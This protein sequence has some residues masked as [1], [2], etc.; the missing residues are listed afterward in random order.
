MATF[1]VAPP[2][3]FSFRPNDWPKWLQRWERFR[4]ASELTKKPEETQI[5]TFIYSMGEDADDI[6]STLPLT[7]EERK[8]YNTVI[9]K[10]ESHFIIKRNVIFERAKF[11][12]RIQQE[13]EPVDAF[14]TDLHTLAQHC[15]YGALHD[16]MIRDRIVVGLRDKALS[17]KLQLESDLTLEKAVNQARQK[18]LVRQQQEVLRPQ[19]QQGIGSIDRLKFKNSTDKK[20]PPTI[21]FTRPKVNP[22]YT[23]CGHCGGKP[24][25]RNEC[26][27]KDSTCNACRK[28]GHWKKMCRSTKKVAEVNQK[29]ESELF[30]GE[31]HIDHLKSGNNQWKVDIMVND[32][33]V[34]FKIDSGA[35]VSVLPV[36]TYEKL[37]N[38]KLQPTSKVLLGPC[39]Y[40]LN[41]MGKFKAKLTVNNLSV[42]NDVYVVKDLERP[43]LSR[44]DSQ[45]LNLINK[46]ETIN[47]FES[48]SEDYKGKIT[49]KYPKLFKGL[50]QIAGE[51]SI[52]L[53][54]H[55]TPFALSVPRKVPLPL[56]SKTKAEIQRML[57]MGV[58]RKVE[59]PTE[60]C[61]PMVV[62]PKANGQ[63]RICVDLTKL[64]ANI[65]REFHPLP[66]VDF[67]LGKL[68]DARV[69]SKLDA[70][71]AF[72]QRALAEESKL[73]TTFITPWGRFCFERLP[74]GISTGSGQ[75]Q[76][77]MME[78]LEGLE[79]VECQ[80]DDIVVHGRTQE[81]HDKR[82]HQVL[83]SLEKANITLNLD[84]CEFNK[85]QIKILG[86]IVSSNRIS[87]DPEKVKAI[88]DLP[89]P[90][91]ISQTRS[92]LGMVNQL[93][94]FTDH[95]ADKTKPIRDLLSEK[96]SWSW[97]Q[98]QDKAFKQIKQCLISPPVLALYD[99]NKKTK[100]TSDASSYGLG[101]VVLQQ[102]DD[103]TWKPVAYFS[104]ALTNTE[105]HYSQ[106]E[107]E[108]L[109]FTWLCERASD[110]I[111]GKPIVGETDHKPLVPMLMTHCLDQLPP[112][113]Q[114][115]RMRLMRF[116]IQEMIHVPGKNMYTSDTLSRMMTKETA[117]KETSQ[118]DENETEAFVCSIMDALPI[119]DLKLQQLIEAQDQDEVCKQLRQYC[120]E[121]W[122]E[123]HLLPSPIHPY[124]SDR[125]Q[126]TVVQN[127]LLM[128]S[129]IVIPS[130][131][132]L[133]VLDKLH[134]GHQGISKC[135]E[136]AKQ[137]VWWP[138]LSKQIQDMID[139][140][141]I[142]LKHKVNRPE[143]LCT[144]LFPQRPWQELGADFFQCQSCDYLIVVDYYSRYIEIAAMNKNKKST[145]VVRALKSIM[146]RH[147][148]PE[149][150]RSDNGPPFDSG[151]YA[152][153]ANEWGFAI[154]T[155]SPKFPRSNGEAERAVQTAKSILKK[156]RDQAKALLAYRSTPL[157]CG[158]SPAQL[159][160]GRC[161]R[162][163]VPTFPSQLD[164][165][166]PDFS[167]LQQYEQSSRVQQQ[168]LYNKKHRAAP[169]SILHPGTEVC[170]KDHD[171]PGIITQKANYP[172][173]YV[174][175]TPLSSLRRNREHLVPSEPYS[176]SPMRART[177][178]DSESQTRLCQTPQVELN[179]KTRPRRTLQPSLKALENMASS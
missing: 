176:D 54:D 43:L 137:T 144:T 40:K 57:D 140:C 104:R 85:S 39:N 29:E 61:A 75:F 82:L 99:T 2:E 132:R 51:Y 136:R 88:A 25:R 9:S 96:N 24:H 66:A 30:L 129:R 68:G 1:T 44:L 69:F 174:V 155:S 49:A 42:E 95:L 162:S 22:T 18:E 118:F 145:E 36:H 11:N 157:S 152:K 28:R 45:N 23:N 110:Y 62:V 58:I 175:Q 173:S 16:E 126:I 60:W 106:I 169:L 7:A 102:Q 77:V 119:S 116:N 84:K 167:T 10:F 114:R 72:W 101:G 20:F 135:R 91:N 50:G 103:D 109:A 35:N 3:K 55:S 153:F 37:E 76:K 93:S 65:K 161:I 80:I 46:I 21:Q 122:P 27:A 92:F 33:L 105:M 150:I 15:S 108:C 170:I 113:I 98:A 158:Y 111:L 63:V 78:T 171:L 115:F 73:L 64:N 125:G 81:I 146:A 74:Y 100:I 160:M 53:K 133:E 142:C 8:V 131:M 34:N 38:T 79:G 168:I 67:T 48:K 148:I 127:V 47:K 12:Q 178:E 149:R 83:D 5:A 70:N 26:P 179:I 121:G 59:V 156:E 130:S 159:L 164:P 112:R 41:C 124:W 128:R 32:Q 56:L 172:R 89:S 166:L 117:S 52:T 107:K 14:I 177:N 94:K 134:E 154:T 17:E 90:R 141:R 165:K 4:V 13:N 86:N 151:E 143:P 163:T 6:F 120:Y 138:G 31:V 87:P 19:G 71:S 147:G 123:K 97:G 139:N